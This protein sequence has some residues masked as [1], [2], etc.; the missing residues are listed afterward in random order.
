MDVKA[1]KGAKATKNTKSF[2]AVAAFTFSLTWSRTSSLSSALEY[3]GYTLGLVLAIL[4]V[5]LKMRGGG[6]MG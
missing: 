5:S 6:R 4:R 2:I 1:V 3:S